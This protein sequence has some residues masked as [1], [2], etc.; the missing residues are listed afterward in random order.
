MKI[1]YMKD[2]A[3]RQLNLKY[4]EIPIYFYMYISSYA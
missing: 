3:Q 4:E 2:K 1:R